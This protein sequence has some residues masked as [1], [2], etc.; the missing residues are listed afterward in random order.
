MLTFLLII[1]LIW[2][3]IKLGVGLT[4][5][6]LFLLACGFA[7]IFFIHLLIPLIIIGGIILIAVALFS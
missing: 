4:K 5:I 6:L 3:F 2:A 7:F 1:F